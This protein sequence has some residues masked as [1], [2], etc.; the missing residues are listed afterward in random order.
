MSTAPHLYN[1]ETSRVYSL[2]DPNHSNAAQGSL[3]IVVLISGSGK[4]QLQSIR[5]F[6]LFTSRVKSPSSHRRPAH[7]PYNATI[8]LV[9]SNRKA[10]FGLQRAASASPP[11]PTSYLALQ[12]YLKSNPDKTRDDYDA[13]IARRVLEAKPDLVVLA[14][15]MHVFGDGFLDILNGVADGGIPDDEGLV[16]PVPVINLHPALP[17]EYD[18]AHAL[19]RAWDDYQ[20]AKIVRTGVMVHRVVKQV[21]AGQPILTREIPSERGRVKRSLRRDCIVSNGRSL[22]RLRRRYWNSECN[23]YE[24]QHRKAR[25]TG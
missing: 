19:D 5:P 2:V 3:R 1:S 4:S 11:I 17:G 13:E 25:L 10:A 9:L 14:G 20:A 6:S 15:W 12:P 21:D 16:R 8:V 22:C 7:F 24:D 23:S 18:G